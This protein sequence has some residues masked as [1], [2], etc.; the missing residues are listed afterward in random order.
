MIKL[1]VSGH[2]EGMTQAA[3]IG[4]VVSASLDRRRSA[5]RITALVGNQ[6]DFVWRTLRRLGLGEADADDAAQ[7]VFLTASRKIDAI[8][9]G[10][11][12]SFLFQ[13]ALR[14]ASDTRRAARRR[15]EDQL[16]DEIDLPA[17][18]PSTDELVELHRARAELDRILDAMPLDLRAVFVLF[19]LE[20]AT[21][22]E[23]AK[24]LDLPAGT[25]ASRLRRA[26]E[27]F[28]AGVK[29]L[30]QGVPVEGGDP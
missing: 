20:Q 27:A 18:T 4:E 22:A 2:G 15:R 28:H 5:S 17:S 1:A 14:V 8:R 10:S 24:L 19:E 16:V 9:L 7:Q 11:E 13:T 21:M 6:Y 3:A 26:R 25:V 12:R 30:D 29:R 23:T